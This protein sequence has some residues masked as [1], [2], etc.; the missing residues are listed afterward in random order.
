MR[1]LSSATSW[2]CS[3]ATFASSS[4]RPGVS[5]PLAT[6][7]AF[8]LKASFFLSLNRSF[9]PT[10]PSSFAEELD[11]LGGARPRV[12]QGDHPVVAQDR[13]LPAQ[14]HLRVAI[15]RDIG[16]VRAAIHDGEFVLAAL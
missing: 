7:S 12:A 3:C 1:V 15:N 5:L 11:Q 2:P 10:V 16:S 13:F 14:H 4:A 6:S 8:S 9:S